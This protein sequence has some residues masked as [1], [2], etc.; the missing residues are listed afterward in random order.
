[1]H[2]H[3]NRQWLRPRDTVEVQIE[4]WPSSTI[5]EAGTTLRLA[6]EGSP[7]IN[8]SNVTHFK[9]PSH[10]FGEVRVWFGG[11][12]DSSPLVRIV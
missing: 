11:E 2:T 4:L 5:W 10:G 7:F 9:S 8:N 1:M 12:Y 6:V 3:Q